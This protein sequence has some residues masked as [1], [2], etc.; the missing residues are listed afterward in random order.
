[1]VGKRVGCYYCFGTLY[2]QDAQEEYRTFVKCEQC[3]GNYHEV[4]WNTCRKCP[5]C[6]G[7]QIHLVNIPQ[8]PPLK[9]GTRKQALSIKPSTIIYLQGDHGASEIH[10][11]RAWHTWVTYLGQVARSLLVGS[12]LVSIISFISTFTYR[13]FNLNLNVNG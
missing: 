6:G 9:M 1:M 11:P 4:C 13:F 7:E 5:V 12:I 2:P 8:P 10:E 3:G